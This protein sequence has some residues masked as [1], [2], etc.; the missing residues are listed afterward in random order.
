MVRHCLRLLPF[1]LLPWALCVVWP[2]RGPRLTLRL[3]RLHPHLLLHQTWGAAGRE[4]VRLKEGGLVV[5]EAQMVAGGQAEVGGAVEGEGL[6]WP[7]VEQEAVL[8][9]KTDE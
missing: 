1:R 5:G 9:G 3:P 6:Q 4:G 7:V 2:Q 8:W